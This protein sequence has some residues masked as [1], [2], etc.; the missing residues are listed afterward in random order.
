[1]YLH[2]TISEDNAENSDDGDRDKPEG[3]RSGAIRAEHSALR[4][5]RLVDVAPEHSAEGF[6]WAKTA[7]GSAIFSDIRSPHFDPLRRPVKD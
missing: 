6:K 2:P 7:E 5:W 1:M 4:F 3:E